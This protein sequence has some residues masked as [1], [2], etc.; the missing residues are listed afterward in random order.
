MRNPHF[1]HPVHVGFIGLLLVLCT[2]AMS[3]CSLREIHEQTTLIDNLG[4]IKGKIR[5]TSD[6]KGPIRVLRFLDEDGNPA[7][8]QSVITNDQ[9][10]Y[11]FPAVPGRYYMAAFIDV[12]NDGKYQAEEH[13]NYYGAPTTIA[14]TKNKTVIVET[15]MINGPVPKPAIE[16]KPIDKTVAI[17][18]NIGPVVTMADPRF[19]PE[20][21]SN[22]LWK[23]VDFLK[24]AEGGVFFLQEYNDNKIPVLLVHGVNNGPTL[25]TQVVDSFDDEYFQPWVYYYPSGFRLDMISDYLVEA[26]TE[27]QDKLEFSEFYVVAHSMGGLVT[28]SFV[29]KYIERSPENLKR[30]GLVMTVNSPMAGMAAA[31]AGVNHSPIVVPSWRDVTPDSEFLKGINDWNWPEEI[32]YHLVTSYLDSESG[33]GVVPLQSQAQWKLQTEATRIYIFNEEHTRIINNKKFHALLNN[34][35][36][37]YSGI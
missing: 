23:P 25:W 30:L 18:K 22:G 24:Q 20:N 8:K 19:T 16:I 36:K 7:L 11:E 33:D 29:K 35:L 9:G 17:W 15:I 3:G 34:L 27:L 2:F 32:P 21:Y 28:R 37:Q 4:T 1:S 10:E 12:N 31:A 26:V 14:V 13:G 5:T 6:Q